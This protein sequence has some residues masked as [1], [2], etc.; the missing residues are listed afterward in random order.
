MME[1]VVS[2]YEK[3]GNLSNSDKVDLEEALVDLADWTK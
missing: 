1:W 2:E 3:R